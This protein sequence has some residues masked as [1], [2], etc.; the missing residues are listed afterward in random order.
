VGRD[1][2]Y[3][4][5]SLSKGGTSQGVVAGGRTLRQAQGDMIETAGLTATTDELYAVGKRT[6]R[7]ALR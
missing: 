7:T 6:Y 2:G 3:V 1:E 4:T 5:L